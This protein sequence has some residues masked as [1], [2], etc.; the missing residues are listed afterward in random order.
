MLVPVVENT[1]EATDLHISP[2]GEIMQHKPRSHIQGHARPSLVRKEQTTEQ[3]RS[4]LTSAASLLKSTSPSDL[5]QSLSASGTAQGFDGDTLKKAASPGAGVEW[6]SHVKQANSHEWLYGYS[7]TSCGMKSS[8]SGPLVQFGTNEHSVALR[9]FLPMLFGG[10]ATAIIAMGRSRGASLESLAVPHDTEQE[11]TPRR[12]DLDCARILCV[13][14][15][16]W[17]HSG[18]WQW[19]QHN[20][21]FSQQWVLPFLYLTSGSSFMLSQKSLSTYLAKLIAVFVVGVLTN[22]FADQFTGRPWHGDF[23]STIAQMAYVAMLIVFSVI[24]APLRAALR[25]REKRQ[26]ADGASSKWIWASALISGFLTCVGFVFLVSP[27]SLS[28]VSSSM[29]TAAPAIGMISN[30]PLAVVQVAGMFWLCHLACLFMATDLL[31][32]FLLLYIYLPRLLIPYGGVGVPHNVELMIF[33]MVAQS[34]KMR[35]QQQIAGVLQGYWALFM[36]FLLLMSCADM[37]GHCD[38]LPASS[39][40]HRARFYGI[41][42]A[43]CVS[44]CTESFKVGDP[45]SFKAIEWLNSW[46][47]YAYCFHVAWARMFTQPY[48]GVFTYTSCIFFCGWAKYNSWQSGVAVPGMKAANSWLYAWLWP[49][50]SERPGRRLSQCLKLGGSTI[51][52]HSA[53]PPFAPVSKP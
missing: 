44:L 17:D 52:L 20:F 16:I 47:L 5:T 18:G 46:A 30:I 33:A 25:L 15:L 53:E 40:W 13:T 41:E 11:A 19:S 14:C 42:L 29:T 36:S 8:S 39:I 10:I 12:L 35:G 28:W 38:L 6:Q 48:G 31:A 51:Q 32:W 7:S 43:F 22:L 26:D 50:W 23:G 1:V 4:E 45:H 2:R 24:A 9:A 3:M 49:N 34:W 27:S 37:Q 21:F